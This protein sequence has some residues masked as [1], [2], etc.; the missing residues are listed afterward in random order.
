MYIMT[1]K[2]ALD[3]CS[4]QKEKTSIYYPINVVYFNYYIKGDKVGKQIIDVLDEE[5]DDLIITREDSF[6]SSDFY[7]DLGLKRYRSAKYPELKSSTDY[8]NYE[9][10]MYNVAKFTKTKEVVTMPTTPTS[11]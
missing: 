5:K 1:E 9:R 4:S 10:D 11:E 3:I 8:A 6:S 7:Y 2:D